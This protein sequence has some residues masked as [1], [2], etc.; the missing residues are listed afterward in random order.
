MRTFQT[1]TLN[2]VYLTSYY[3]RNVSRSTKNQAKRK[4]MLVNVG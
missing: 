1:E 4:L 3:G 2:P